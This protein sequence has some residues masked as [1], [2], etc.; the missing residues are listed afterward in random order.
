[1]G[2][3]LYATRCDTTTLGDRIAEGTCNRVST[4]SV[5]SQQTASRTE[6]LDNVPTARGT[7]L[8]GAAK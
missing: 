2:I 6:K 1:M 7:K 5:V 4:G 8:S 3:D